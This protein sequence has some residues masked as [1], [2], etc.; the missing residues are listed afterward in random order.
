LISFKD[1]RKISFA[2]GKNDFPKLFMEKTDFN[3]DIMETSTESTDDY[4][5]AK[6]PLWEAFY[7]Y[8]K[9]SENREIREGLLEAE[10]RFDSVH[11]NTPHFTYGDFGE[12]MNVLAE[13]FEMR[14]NYAIVSID[15]PYSELADRILSAQE[16]C[17]AVYDSF[18]AKY[19]YDVHDPYYG[20]EGDEADEGDDGGPEGDG[21]S[22]DTYYDEL[23]EPVSEELEKFFPLHK[24]DR[25][26]VVDDYQLGELVGIRGDGSVL[27][28]GRVEDFKARLGSAKQFIVSLPPFCKDGTCYGRCYV[29]IDD[30]QYE[31][32]DAKGAVWLDFLKQMKSRWMLTEFGVSLTYSNTTPFTDFDL[33]E[34]LPESVTHVSLDP[35]FVITRPLERVSLLRVVGGHHPVYA[36]EKN[37]SFREENFPVLVELSV[38]MGHQ[39]DPCDTIYRKL[40]DER[41]PNCKSRKLWTS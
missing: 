27:R 29:T 15:I 40:M 38:D 17:I 24:E 1:K 3:R 7:I 35:R 11:R 12:F 8:P 32:G 6:D 16:R 20:R 23:I 34:V 39:G 30:I 18:F 21:F 26:I 9:L 33:C 19:G 36:I 31:L 25:K 28:E 10:G 41:F 2:G 5:Q 14:S 37:T 22:C 13:H 4:E